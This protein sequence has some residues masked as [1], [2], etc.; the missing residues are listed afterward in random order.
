MLLLLGMNLPKKVSNGYENTP[1]HRDFDKTESI[2][3][4]ITVCLRNADSE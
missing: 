4:A 3:I 2:A 1:L